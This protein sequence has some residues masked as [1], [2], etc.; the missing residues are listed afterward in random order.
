MSKFWNFCYKIIIYTFSILITIWILS[1]GV[2]VDKS[3][4]V[5][6]VAI[7]LALL[8]TFI[9]PLLFMLTIPFTIF[10]MGL[11][12]F[13]VNAFMVVLAGYF[14]EGFTVDSF[15]W[16]LAFSLLMPV[17]SFILSIPEKIRKKQIIIKR[18]H[19]DGAADNPDDGDIQE[20]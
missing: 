5:V 7:V 15:G 10:T 3:I 4:T 9:R 20:F 17:F 1:K 2:H 12:V 6:L 14:V 19:R 8:N 16:A 13:V 18:M 11:F